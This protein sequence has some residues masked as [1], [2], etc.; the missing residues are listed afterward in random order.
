MDDIIHVAI[1]KSASNLTR[2]FSCQAL[3]KV[4]MGYDVVKQLDTVLRVSKDQIVV[5]II[6][7]FLKHFANIGVMKQ[8]NKSGFAKNV[9]FSF[10]IMIGQARGNGR[11]IDTFDLNRRV[12]SRHD[13]DSNLISSDLMGGEDD[14]SST[15]KS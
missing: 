3:A 7:H 1:L 2:N 13:L 14:L 12:E 4:A 11:W 5:M 10:H 9:L 8:V 15:S 6:D